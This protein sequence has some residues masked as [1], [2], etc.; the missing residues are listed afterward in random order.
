[1]LIFN[2]VWFDKPSPHCE[3]LFILFF[4]GNHCTQIKPLT[5]H[6]FLTNFF[7]LVHFTMDEN[8]IFNYG[9]DRHW[10]ECTGRC[11]PKTPLPMV[12]QAPYPWYYDPPTH[13]ISSPLSMVLW[14]PI[15]GIMTPLPMVY[16]A[17]YPWYYDPF[18]HDISNPPIHGIMTP[19][20]WYIEPPIHGIMTP[21]PWYIEP[22]PMVL[23]PPYPWY[24]DPLPMVYWTPY[25]WYY[26]PPTHGISNPPLL[27]EMRG[28]NLL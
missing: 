8:R 28:F 11:K 12:Y 20:P 3:S 7:T 26:D 6:K 10:T 9:G 23:W 24:Y 2:S 18:T 16:Q 22:L 4:R 19:Y 5:C 15:H 27:V 25:P 14:P 13:G 1:M 21:Y 17:P